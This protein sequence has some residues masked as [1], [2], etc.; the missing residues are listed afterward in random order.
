[1]KQLL[2]CSYTGSFNVFYNLRPNCIFSLSVIYE[3]MEWELFVCM[4]SF[5]YVCR[6][7]YASI[8]VYLSM[9][10]A[11]VYACMHQFMYIFLCIVRAC[12]CV[13]MHVSYI[14]T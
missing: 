8:Y 1:M 3:E 10:C 12:M 11:C 7:M 13:F 5:M 2:C 4:Y 9:Y 14:R 6:P